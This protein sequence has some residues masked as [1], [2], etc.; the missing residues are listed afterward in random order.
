MLFG[1]LFTFET[2]CVKILSRSPHYVFSMLCFDILSGDSL[3]L[4]PL[5]V[6]VLFLIYLIFCSSRGDKQSNRWRNKTSSCGCSKATH[7][8]DAVI[9][10]FGSFCLS[11]YC[12]DSEK[13]I[14]KLSQRGVTAFSVANF[15]VSIADPFLGLVVACICVDCYIMMGSFEVTKGEITP[16][17]T[18]RE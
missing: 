11:A 18:T 9:L 7:R 10:G 6:F 12:G 14:I 13:Y 16:A 15:V 2:I 1:I 17:G 5:R 8:E 3:S 4:P